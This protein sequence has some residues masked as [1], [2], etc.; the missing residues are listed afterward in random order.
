MK[1]SFVHGAAALAW[2]SL[3]CLLAAPL[4]AGTVFRIILGGPPADR[5]GEYR[6]RVEVDL[7]DGRYGSVCARGWD[8]ELSTG[9]CNRWNGYWHYGI[10]INGSAFGPAAQVS[11]VVLADISCVGGVRQ[12]TS[13]DLVAGAGSNCTATVY[14]S[15]AAAEADGCGRD[16]AAGVNCFQYDYLTPPGSPPLP[17]RLVSSGNQTAL[18]AAARAGLVAAGRLEVQWGG[19]WGGVCSN[20]ASGSYNWWS[21][22]FAQVVCRQLGYVDGHAYAVG[23]RNNP[24]L[25]GPPPADQ[26]QFITYAQCNGSEPGLGWC[27]GFPINGNLSACSG[28]DYPVH[29]ACYSQER[30]LAL[31][32]PGLSVNLVNRTLPPLG[33]GE[34][35][36]RPEAYGPGRQVISICDRNWTDAAATEFCKLYTYGSPQGMTHG[37]AFWGSYFG[38]NDPRVPVTGW[39]TDLRCPAGDESNLGACLGTLYTNSADAAAAG[40]SNATVAGVRCFTYDYLTPPGS[41][42][43]HLRLVS[44]GNQTALDAAARAGLVAAGRLE[45][46][47]GGM[48]GGVCSSS[49]SSSF[50]YAN[51]DWWRDVHAQVVCRQLGYVDGHAY[52]V[53][54]RNALLPGPLN[55]TN[56]WLTYVQ[57]NG[58][59]LGLG[60][61]R[62]LPINSTLIQSSGGCRPEDSVAVACYNQKRLV[63]SFGPGYIT[64]QTAN[65]TGLQ[66]GSRYG[67]SQGRPEVRLSPSNKVIG[68]CD[69]GWD[70]TAASAWCKISTA[71]GYAPTPYG[72]SYTGSYYG[73][74]I[75]S[76]ATAWLADLRCPAGDEGN[77]GA[78]LGT[79]YAST[80]EAAAAGCTAAT[81]AGVKCFAYD[82]LTPPGSP[83]LH[84]RLVSSGNQTA[85]DAAARAGLVAAG[86]LEVQWG[87]VW[88][89]VCSNAAS[90]TIDWWRDPHAQVACRQLGYAD[91]HAYGAG[92][93]NPLIPGPPP[94]DQPQFLTYLQ[95]NGSEPGLGACRGKPINSSSPACGPDSAVHVA[96]YSQR[97]LQEL[98]GPV[99]G[100][101]LGNA[102]TPPNSYGAAQ[103]RPELRLRDGRMAALCDR[104]FDDAAAS[105][106][107]QRI[108]GGGMYGWP[109]GMSYTGSYFGSTAGAATWLADLRCPTGDEGNLASCLATFYNSSAE[110]AA[111]GCGNTTAA[112][113][114]CFSYDYLTPPGSP[115][116]PLRLVSSGNQTALDA[117]ARA[118]LV[119]VGRLE[120][121]WGGVWGG[122]C[123]NA[124]SWTIDWW[125][126][127]HAQVVCRQLGYVDGHAYAVGTRNN[128]LLPG[129]PPADQP[130]F[131]TYA[132]C[133]GS[134]PGLGACRGKPI[135][136]SLPSCGPDSAVHVAC[137]SQQRLF[138]KLIAASNLTGARPANFL[139]GVNGANESAPAYGYGF[140]EGQVVLTFPNNRRVSVCDRAWDDE[141]AT[142]FCRQRFYTFPVQMYGQAI[143]GSYFGSDP[144]TPALIADL[145][146]PAGDEP[147]LGM[148]LGTLFASGAE[149]A[150][151]GCTAANTAGYRCF[152]FDYILSRAAARLPT[153]LVELNASYSGVGSSGSGGNG[154]SSGAQ[155]QL[156]LGRVEVQWAGVWG[157]VC[158]SRLY[159]A[160]AWWNNAA[161]RVACRAAGYWGGAAYQPNYPE[162]LLPAGVADAKEQ[163][164]LQ[165]QWLRYAQ[166]AG[167]E[168]SLGSCR[169]PPLNS[170]GNDGGDPNTAC[171]DADAVFASCYLTPPAGERVRPPSPPPPIPT[172]QAP[173]QPA[174]GLDGGGGGSSR[175][176]NPPPPPRPPL[177]SAE[178]LRNSTGGV[179]VTAAAE[180]YPE[181][182]SDVPQ[183][184]PNLFPAA[185]LALLGPSLPLLLSPQQQVVAAATRTRDGSS[186]DGNGSSNGNSSGSG[187]L[188]VP[189]WAFARPLLPDPAPLAANSTADAS[190]APLAQPPRPYNCS[191]YVIGTHDTLYLLPYIQERL[192]SYVAGG[193]GLVVA[194]PDLMPSDFYGADPHASGGAVASAAAEGAS[195]GPQRRLQQQPAGTGGGAA[196]GGAVNA[197]SQQPQ[198]PLG[199]FEVNAVTAPLGLVLTGFVSDPGGNL[200]LAGPSLARNAELAA[201]QLVGYLQGRLPLSQPDLLMLLGTTTRARAVM[202]GLARG[203]DTESSGG[204][205]MD[206]VA[207][208]FE[209]F[210]EL[211]RQVDGLVA[212]APANLLT[213]FASPPPP[214]PSVRR[215]PPSPPPRPPPRPQ[216]A[217][218]VPRPSQLQ[219]PPSPLSP[220][221]PPPPPA[222][223][224]PAPSPPATD[225][226][227]AQPQRRAPSAAGRSGA[228][229]RRPPPRMVVVSGDAAEAVLG[230]GRQ[231]SQQ[232]QQ[233]GA[234]V[235]AAAGPAG[236]GSTAGR[237]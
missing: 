85:L 73:T 76:Y 112:G 94:A 99:L 157:G 143:G 64:P 230:K 204:S 12:A 107:C 121:Q 187:W 134:E 122:V 78:C 33:Y 40:C 115:P 153:R 92:L 91:G 144:T 114:R 225:T 169:G 75:T 45:V 132:Q 80:A 20:A 77:L 234:S 74:S 185:T 32:G 67:D 50:S 105:T 57:C 63:A 17:L 146:C 138:T 236:D 69:R 61:C 150:A 128:P 163:R 54:T 152:R 199:S 11:A 7:P 46:Q 84:L 39:L 26:P 96:C 159:G 41:P 34:S 38:T 221:P 165:P 211:T 214:P 170:T 162:Q 51:W 160:Q 31:A 87:G 95:C 172:P 156:V 21:D 229:G 15:A 97:R 183:T 237:R 117:A 227:G 58:T 56:Y 154:S 174:V 168:A 62:G 228:G 93:S 90:W 44:S 101:Q 82:F 193:G 25:P 13:L 116:L 203:T 42:P 55:Q 210:D 124:A 100:F 133:S 29:V 119:A 232:Q 171:T 109:Y 4:P 167:E 216:P 208:A 184:L 9:V 218:P 206:A 118:G 175:G 52:K 213:V 137:Y 23:T 147:S 5:Y 43:L 22:T 196:G 28:P 86:R 104:G 202:A 111:A 224:S 194:G 36:G 14:E 141:A 103:G 83:P 70:D 215:P 226:G 186:N 180:D 212:T 18:D 201:A 191:V 10:P 231:H 8:V 233:A 123:S 219:P 60:A 2:L 179:F 131:I 106:A 102:S 217:P 192:V 197:P 1:N 139:V 16:Q 68:L 71:D 65:S 177:P 220:L 126:D 89:G 53:G 110:A 49:S 148:C 198:L 205:T 195:G 188:E 166:C 98:L 190:G 164:L 81:N 207:L 155:P 37:A 223:P 19:V 140:N 200:T 181:I 145:R 182:V 176:V 108:A 149:A 209:R 151:N 161:A 120:V 142:F 72:V 178:V 125:R 66:A 79:F 47:W 27:R 135:N 30:L 127:P 113:V 130:Q 222:P 136:S 24:L 129:P 48:W 59:E 235:P 3:V 189:L 35:Q 88:G 158:S 173:S 6:G